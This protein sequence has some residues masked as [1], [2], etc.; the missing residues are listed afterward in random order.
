MA[1]DRIIQL[2]L[3]AD[4]SNIDK[5]LAGT[6]SRLGRLGASFK[7]FAGAVALDTAITAVQEVSDRLIGGVDDWKSYQQQIGTT[8]TLLNS[9]GDDFDV[10]DIASKLDSL[11]FDA[12]FADDATLE[13]FN[14]LLQRTQDV[15][16]ATKGVELAF[17]LARAKGI[18]LKTAAQEVGN[19]YKGEA[20]KLAEYG[21]TSDEVTKNSASNWDLALGQ[22]EGRAEEFSGTLEGKLEKVGTFFDR[23]FANV[24]GFGLE[25]LEDIIPV[26]E[27]DLLPF[28]Q[29]LFEKAQPVVF[30]VGK[31][32]GKLG[33]VASI[34]V[35]RLQ[36]VIGPLI[37]VTFSQ[38]ETV[39]AGISGLLDTMVALLN[40]DFTGAWEAIKRTITNVMNGIKNTVRTALN[41]VIDLWNKLDFG[42]NI[43][44]P[45]PTTGNGDIDDLL[46][47]GRGRTLDWKTGDL[48]PD[49]PRLASG[50]IVTQPT[51]ALIGEAGREAIVPL[52][53][54]GY[55]NTVYLTQNINGDPSV[56]K[57][58]VLEALRI[59][60]MNNG[61]L[62][63][64]DRLRSA[65][66]R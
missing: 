30:E 36:P 46:G 44:I 55:G 38:M 16:T 8:E 25:A 41:F 15:E 13:A 61:S 49:I 57:A 34:I 20:E 62:Q 10:D 51:I 26:L 54:G 19:V 58:A 45:L 6:S 65:R 11:S 17:D 22:I 31:I 39:L 42:I 53:E 60:G 32:A 33:E 50:G 3:L 37:D 1:V 29:E 47:I 21:V 23:A 35:D 66:V 12:G 7:G 14:T 2:K 59:A 64:T 40:G 43:S 56:I 28:L 27:E 18:D 9:L 5:Q 63:V 52:D 24:S 4:V 48:I